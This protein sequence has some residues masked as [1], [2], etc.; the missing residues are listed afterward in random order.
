MDSDGVT[1]T[2]NDGQQIHYHKYKYSKL[3]SSTSI[4]LIKPCRDY[5]RISRV[6]NEI[7]FHFSIEEKS[8][9]DPDID[10]KALSYTWGSNVRVSPLFLGGE[11]RGKVL[12]TTANA[13]HALQRLGHSP[14]PE[15]M[16]VD[17]I[18][19]H[20]DDVDERN[21]QVALMAKIYSK[22]WLCIVWLGIEN[23][24]DEDTKAAFEL[25]RKISDAIPTTEPL[26][27]SPTQL[28]PL[29]HGEIR[30]RLK[31]AYG[32]D[33]L[34][35]ADYDGWTA[36][37]RCLHRAWFTRLW[38]FQ[39]V[40][41]SKDVIVCC[42]WQNATLIDFTRAS[43]FLGI[44]YEFPVPEHPTGRPT[45]NIIDTYIWRY[46]NQH[47]NPLLL[48]LSN[49]RNTYECGDQ[50]DR[51]YALL[52]V[53]SEDMKLADVV[54]AY[55]EPVAELFTKTAKTLISTSSSLQTFDHVNALPGGLVEGLPSWVPD[56][57][58]KASSVALDFIDLKGKKFRASKGRCHRFIPSLQ[59]REIIVSGSAVDKVREVINLKLQDGTTT[60]QRIAFFTK[61]L[62]PTVLRLSTMDNDESFKQNRLKLIKTL[63]I[64]GQLRESRLGDMGFTALDWQL[65]VVNEMLDAFTHRTPYSFSGK[66]GVQRE[67]EPLD[68]WLRALAT[69]MTSCIGRVLVVL[70]KHQ[71]GL[72]SDNVQTGDI[73]AVLHGSSV[74]V[75]LRYKNQDAYALV[76]PCFVDGIMY[77]DAVNWE[78]DEADSFRII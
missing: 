6:N 52:G 13:W 45:L 50:H 73:V 27:M 36:F 66:P 74:P 62:L 76:G 22:C 57:S 16:W 54:I 61:E 58:A 53:Q 32:I 14:G 71:L 63:T 47:E 75:I 69:Q 67:P 41:V 18:C 10:F 78:V 59:Q 33:R 20:Q 60:D 37:A 51:I 3:S 35:P 40:V 28:V 39:E 7:L 42:G 19:I 2:K 29:S 24:G 65:D 70:S 17:Q 30:E 44:E 46:R 21:Q 38:T 26:P 56:W 68:H 8:L 49:T 25:V 12:M 9:D 55:E 4:R 11:V 34:P 64:D 77:G 43:A 31:E 1:V 48:L 72:C 5:Q 23:A 15:Y